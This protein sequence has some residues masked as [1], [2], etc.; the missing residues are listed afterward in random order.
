MVQDVGAERTPD[1]SAATLVDQG[2]FAPEWGPLPAVLDTACVRTGLHFQLAKGRPPLTVQAARTG[3]LSLFVEYDTL[4]ETIHRLPRFANQLKVAEA[5]LR[6]IFNEDWLPN[7]DVARLPEFW[8][9]VDHRAREV[10]A[11]DADDYPAAALAA[12]LSP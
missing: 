7:I 1:S 9:E 10:R 8:R 5:E 2:D 6:R 12:L 3:S 11:L 4:I